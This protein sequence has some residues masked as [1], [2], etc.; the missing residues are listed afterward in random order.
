MAYYDYYRDK[1]LDA[2]E[3]KTGLAGVER[4]SADYEASAN[5][6][7]A[8]KTNSL[9]QRLAGTRRAPGGGIRQGMSKK[10]GLSANNATSGLTAANAA[11]RKAR[12][13]E[14]VKGQNELNSLSRAKSGWDAA[15]SASNSYWAANPAQGFTIYY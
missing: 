15:V 7:A 4:E 12:R 5:A 14:E 3:L 9:A 2:A 1:D 10:R 13:I 8:E 11:G 6:A